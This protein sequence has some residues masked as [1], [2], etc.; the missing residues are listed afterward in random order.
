MPLSM[1]FPTSPLLLRGSSSD[2]IPVSRGCDNWLGR[3]WISDEGIRLALMCLSWRHI[4]VGSDSICLIF[5]SLPIHEFFMR[6]V[7]ETDFEMS[8]ACL[9]CPAE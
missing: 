6:G 8:Y 4:I 3:W 1:L 2:P 7:L 5:A 9:P